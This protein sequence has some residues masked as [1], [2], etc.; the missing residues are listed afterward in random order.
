MN[1]KNQY[2]KTGNFWKVIML[3]MGVSAMTFFVLARLSF[4]QSEAEDIAPV[5][6]QLQP[7]E[8]P[9]RLQSR[10]HSLRQHL[11]GAALAPFVVAWHI[12]R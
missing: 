4:A 10:I 12:F 1:T 11:L 5:K 3:I 2:L 8:E 6:E 9:S 7:L